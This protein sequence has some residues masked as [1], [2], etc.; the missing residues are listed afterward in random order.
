MPS[1]APAHLNLPL[2]LLA[3]V[4][5]RFEE[6]PRMRVRTRTLVTVPCAST[7]LVSSCRRGGMVSY[8]RRH[9]RQNAT[10]SIETTE[11]RDPTVMRES[12]LPS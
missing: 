11:F 7:R 6:H 12:S 3:F 2:D 4:V 8:D 9:A 1:T 10:A 5:G